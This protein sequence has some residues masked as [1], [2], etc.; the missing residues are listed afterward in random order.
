MR[1]WNSIVNKYNVA[2]NI[3]SMIFNSDLYDVNCNDMCTVTENEKHETISQVAKSFDLHTFIETGT[4]RG[5]TIDAVKEYFVELYSIEIGEELTKKAQLRFIN[6]SNIHIWQGNSAIILPEILKG[7]KMP[8]CFWLDAHPSGG[9]TEGSTTKVPILSEI[10]SILRHRKDHV[11][12]IDDARYFNGGISRYP[13]ISYLSY[14]VKKEDPNMSVV[15]RD[16][17]IR[18]YRDVML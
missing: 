10:V 15:V 6:Y 2:R 3:I 9:D 14:I 16:D 5:D 13:T 1:G 7:V 8:C 12:L 11:I 4:Y 18:I 17:I